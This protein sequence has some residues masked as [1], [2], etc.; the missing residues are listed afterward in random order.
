MHDPATPESQRV[1]DDRRGGRTAG[2]VLVL[3]VAFI[4]VA[5]TKPWGS[6]V[7]PAPF[8]PPSRADVTPPA[9]PL[10][11]T[12]PEVPSAGPSAKVGP[13]PVAFTTPTRP[14]SATWIGLHWRRLAPDDP[15]SLVT[16]V[17]QWRRGY[18]AVGWQA[19][20]PLTPVWTSG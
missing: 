2:L 3:I 14:A 15:L 10:P 1:T 13:L 4:G 9:A 5:I 18:V 12:A 19:E 17:V 20:A 7:A 8:V 6:P 11:T 16:S